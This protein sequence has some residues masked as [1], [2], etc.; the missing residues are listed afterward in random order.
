MS[1]DSAE[2][3]KKHLKLYFGVF[4]ALLVGTVITVWASYWHFDSMAV[5]VGVA[6]L[7]A[8]VK[9]FLVAGY[10]MHLTTEKKTI[11]AIM[12]ATMFFFAGLMA[13]FIWSRGALPTGTQWWE[14]SHSGGAAIEE[15]AH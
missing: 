11:Y 7:I 15:K 3:V 12:G 10:F 2:D 13:L 6:L 5:T 1:A 8:C 9:A 14:G 4:G